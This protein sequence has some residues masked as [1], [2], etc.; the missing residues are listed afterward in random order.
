LLPSAA[1]FVDPL[2]STGF[3][4]TLLGV[5]RLAE[6]IDCDWQKGT[7]VQALDS[8]ASQ[9]DD[10]LLTTGSLIGALYAN[11]G[12]F[13]VFSALSLIY[14][15]AVSYSEAAR[16]LGK[17]HLAQGFLLHN[18]PQFGPECAQ[19]LD[20]A[21]RIR[22]Q[23]ESRDLIE[24]IFRLIEPF[25]V[26]G[27]GKRNRFNWYPV[28]AEDILHSAHKL[29]ATKMEITEMLERCGFQPAISQA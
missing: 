5:A 18:H 28:E 12:N 4:L 14:F 27:L 20:R 16:R 29:G 8:Y 13:G 23:E 10:D 7:M 22:T 2:L 26:A 17:G 24:E 21:R 6:I 11:M 19:I 9:T 3:P 25:D 1:G 15:A